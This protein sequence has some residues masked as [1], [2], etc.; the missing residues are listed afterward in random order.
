MHFQSEKSSTGFTRLQGVH[1]T[2][3]EGAL[4]SSTQVESLS[5]LKCRCPGPSHDP[6]NRNLRDWDL[7]VCFSKAPQVMGMQ[8]V[9]VRGLLFGNL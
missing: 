3:V 6:L 1:G 7:D 4:P 2:N 5:W 8:P 9:Q